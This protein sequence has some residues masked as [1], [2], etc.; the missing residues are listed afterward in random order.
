M[1]FPRA[2]PRYQALLATGVAV[3]A[4]YG[5]FLL[6]AQFAFLKSLQVG[7]T[8]EA[9]AIKEVLAVMGLLGM[10]GSVFTARV[11]TPARGR[12][13]LAA[14][15]AISAAAAGLLLAGGPQRSH[16]PVAMLVG[17]GLG[18][19]TV[20][21]AS[22][23]RLVVGDARLGTV[24][25]LGTGMAYA[26]CN[27]PVI[28][29]ASWSAQTGIALAVALLG[30]CSLPWLKRQA[31]AVPRLGW[32]YS[33][34]GVIIWVVIFFTLVSLDS[35]AFYII[36]HSPPLKAVTWNGVGRL[37]LNALLHLTGGLLAGLALDRHWLGRTTFAA[38]ACLVGAGLL[39]VWGGPVGAAATVVY[40]VGVSI[41]SSALVYYPACSDRPGLAA[42]IYAV[43][44][45]GGSALGIALVENLVAI[46]PGMLV[47]AAAGFGATFLLR[48]RARRGLLL[49]LGLAL[50]G[51]AVGTPRLWA[52]TDPRLAAG[53]RVYL[54][55]GCI[56]CHS[57]YVRPGTADAEL[58]GPAHPLAELLAQTPP[59][60][61]NR[62]QGP[63]LLNV[64][65]R[66]PRDWNRQHLIAPRTL[67]PGSRMPAY[68]YLFTA[69]AVRGEALLDYLTALGLPPRP[70]LQK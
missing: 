11:F 47:T 42:G 26:F 41:Y 70:A 49:L 16:F 17:L 63:D 65:G 20:S 34:N 30:L 19:V 27:L 23:L 28:F 10:A 7:A 24:I 8:M 52:Q 39:L 18:L 13:L 12:G 1:P 51:G 35:A 64:G 46:P 36:Q 61:G 40:T 67:S 25:G 21:L 4:T 60:F 31:P 57:Q 29:T 55:E 15:F 14:G 68:G 56:H 6:F 22:L 5:Y 9:G 48:S 32:D 58:W 38:A 33:R 2:Q 66:R 3:T 69:E 43:A 62:R 45:W 59:L 44:G 37:E 50:L 53:R 54:A